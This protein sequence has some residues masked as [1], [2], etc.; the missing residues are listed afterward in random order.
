MPRWNDA[1]CGWEWQS[2]YLDER[3][4][5]LGPEADRRDH[6]VH[7]LLQLRS[8]L[9]R[10]VRAESL[11]LRRRVWPAAAAA[12]VRRPPC[13][14]RGSSHAVG[15]LRAGVARGGAAARLE[16]RQPIPDNDA[17]PQPQLQRSNERL[18]ALAH[19]A[20]Y[21]ARLRRYN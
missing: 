18:H 2:L 11:Q 21:M 8:L 7:A 16:V 3:C 6:A 12:A 17:R 5:L 15:A 9:H 20:L 10:R 4:A 1:A 13:S 14:R 19:T